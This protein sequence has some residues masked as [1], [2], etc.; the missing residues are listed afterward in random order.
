VRTED[1][2]GHHRRP[3]LVA[4]RQDLVA[5]RSPI[6]CATVARTLAI[7]LVALTA[8]YLRLRIETSCVREAHA[9]PVCLGNFRFHPPCS[10]GSGECPCARRSSAFCFARIIQVASATLD[11]GRTTSRAL[12]VLAPPASGFPPKKSGLVLGSRPRRLFR[13]RM[14]GGNGATAW[15]TDSTDAFL[16]HSL[17]VCSRPTPSR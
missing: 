16:V 4:E 12:R 9:G 7:A 10:H 5:W 15:T 17:T 8:F 14:A 3:A 11:A 13:A 2:E 6:N 1:D